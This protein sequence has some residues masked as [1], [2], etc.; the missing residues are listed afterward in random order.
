MQ[1]I[2]AE[3][4]P[5][6]GRLA[7]IAAALTVVAALALVPHH[8]HARHHGHHRAHGKCPHG[9]VYVIR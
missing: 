1:P 5:H 3:S 4:V 7:A 6:R 9:H 8:P 2:F